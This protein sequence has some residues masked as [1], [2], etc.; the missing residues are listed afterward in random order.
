MLSLSEPLGNE[1]EYGGKIYRIDLS[2]DAVLR[3][4]EMLDDKRLTDSD[5][6]RS[7]F[8]LFFNKD[9]EDDINYDFALSAFEQI[10]KYIS[11]KPY[12]HNDEEGSK[13]QVV[14]D[15]RRLYSFKQDAEAIYSSFMEQYGIDLIDQ[16]GKLHWDK[17][18]A[19]FDGLGS[20]TYFQRIIAI[21][22]KSTKDLQG[23]EL[24]QVI[25]AQQYYELDYNRSQA[26]KE[27]QFQNFG[28][29]LKNWAQ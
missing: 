5:K 7:A 19:L 28:E 20:Q 14:T 25:Q 16:Q 13:D 15:P 4:Y 26:A 12:G 24:N 8:E 11:M 1:F 23:E 22:T 17:F 21:R 2:F 27:A 29:I 6:L 18:K 10:S 3:Y 9:D